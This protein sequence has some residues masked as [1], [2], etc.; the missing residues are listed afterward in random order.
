MLFCGFNDPPSRSYALNRLLW[1]TD[2][3]CGSH[4]EYQ[5]HVSTGYYRS[6]LPGPDGAK[7]C[8][9]CDLVDRQAGR[10]LGE[11]EIPPAMHPRIRRIYRDEVAQ[12]VEPQ[13]LQVERLRWRIAELEEENRG[14]VRLLAQ[15]KISETEFDEER[16]RVGSAITKAR[17]ELVALE[18]G[19]RGTMDELDVALKFFSQISVLWE[20][21]DTAHRKLIAHLVFKRIS[22]SN[23]GEIVDYRL[24]PPFEYLIE[25]KK[26]CSPGRLY[27]LKD[28]DGYSNQ[29]A[30]GLPLRT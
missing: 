29:V 13:R 10:L 17:A 23:T 14:Y 15:R 8:L 1:F 6:K 3:H 22:I 5:A 11:L 20:H 26:A 12:F 4:A 21:A 24:N 18:Q 28:T 30:S 25:A 9:R 16:S 19:S 27:T 2:L 7:I